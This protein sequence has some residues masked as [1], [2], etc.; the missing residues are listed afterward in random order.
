LS[1]QSFQKQILL[2]LLILYTPPHY[3]LFLCKN[4]I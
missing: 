3:Y 2:H 4:K 1:F